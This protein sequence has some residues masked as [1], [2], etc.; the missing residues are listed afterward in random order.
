MNAEQILSQ[1]YSRIQA[2]DVTGDFQAEAE[3]YWDCLE[4]IRLLI[5][6]EVAKKHFA[7]KTAPLG[8]GYPTDIPMEF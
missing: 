4:E 3:A 2:I 5:P 7:G 1:I 8:E 6:Y